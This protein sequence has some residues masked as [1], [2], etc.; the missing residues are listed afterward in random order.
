[1]STFFS[2][3]LNVLRTQNLKLPAKIKAFYYKL[4]Y[5]FCVFMW[6]VFIKSPCQVVFLCLLDLL[7]INDL[8]ETALII[9][10]QNITF[11]K[12]F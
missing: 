4:Q 10:K 5:L 12:A 1:M 11:T 7:P 3:S 8:F 2:L 9:R 6:M